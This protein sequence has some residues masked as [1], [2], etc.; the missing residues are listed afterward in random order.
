MS[1]PNRQKLI[2][3]LDE[4]NQNRLVKWD[5]VSFGERFYRSQQISTFVFSTMEEAGIMICLSMDNLYV[6]YEGFGS[7]ILTFVGIMQNHGVKAPRFDEIYEYLDARPGKVK[8]LLERYQ[9][10]SEDFRVVSED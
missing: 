10:R 9:L 4:L 3:V 2:S 1:K 7:D 5:Y 6:A 8:S